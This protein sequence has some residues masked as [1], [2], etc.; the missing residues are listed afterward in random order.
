MLLRQWSMQALATVVIITITVTTTKH[1]ITIL[2]KI[3]V[4]I[5][6]ATTRRAKRHRNSH[7]I[8]HCVFSSLR[9]DTNTSLKFEGFLQLTLLAF[10]FCVRYFGPLQKVCSARNDQKYANLRLRNLHQLQNLRNMQSQQMT[11][12]K[13]SNR[14]NH[15]YHLTNNKCTIPS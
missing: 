15:S 10:W 9:T 8:S 5:T 6:A 4:K 13:R 3:K 7:P 1:T 2:I 12:T 14:T 11:A